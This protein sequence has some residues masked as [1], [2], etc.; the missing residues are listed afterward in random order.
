V[1]GRKESPIAATAV[2][3]VT[4]RYGD[5]EALTDVSL[6]VQPGEIVAVLGPNGAGKSTLLGVMAGALETAKGVVRLFGEPTTTQDRRDIAK[7]VAFVTQSAEVAFG[8][9]VREVVMMG[10]APHQA[11]WMVPS[12]ADVQV[13]DEAIA[14]CELH[15]LENRRVDAL[16]GGEQKRVAIAR[17]MAQ[18]PKLLLLDEPGAFLDVRHQLALYD[19]LARLT[20]QKL[21]VVLSMHDI[22]AA[23][24]YAS[25]IALL[26]SGK[27]V[28][29]GS[30][31]EVLTYRR[32]RETFD[33]DLYC[34]INDVTGVRF[35]LPMRAQPRS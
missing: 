3:Q 10:R 25:R 8:F 16:S 2:E 27:L 33:A 13:V 5:F 4:V 26:K 21:A 6:E 31:E 12:A 32:L 20:A 24:Q 35:F 29:I 17:A 1:P 23:A 11:G 14:M 34:G 28:G 19:L 18:S 30:V 7:R 15:G 22:N 9:T